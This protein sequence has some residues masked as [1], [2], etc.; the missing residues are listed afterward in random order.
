M[1]SDHCSISSNNSSN[2][3]FCSSSDSSEDINNALILTLADSIG[4]VGVPVFTL[5]GGPGY[6]LQ[7]TFGYLAGF[8]VGAFILGIWVEKSGMAER[9]IKFYMA[10]LLAFIAI[11]LM[12]V[13]YLYINMKYLI[14]KEISIMYAI[15]SGILVFIPG[16]L[17]KIVLS[18]WITGKCRKLLN[19]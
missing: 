2:N 14:G 6:V 13:V 1:N 12:G 15:L 10:H 8:P 11:F 4:L 7:P 16:E 5:G 17:L 18:V 19:F 3:F 9:L